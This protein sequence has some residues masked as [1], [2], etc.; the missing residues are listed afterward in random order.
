MVFERLFHPNLALT[1]ADK[2]AMLAHALVAWMYDASTGRLVTQF[3]AAAA[4]SYPLYYFTTSLSNDGT[5]VVFH[6]ERSGWVQ[7]Y[8]LDLF[9]RRR[10]RKPKPTSPAP[11]NA[12]VVGSGTGGGSS[13]FTFGV[14]PMRTC[15]TS[16]AS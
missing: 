14:R 13:S 11:S 1:L 8:R 2:R 5:Y 4:N 6:S 15:L 16:L 3:T 10:R 12:R 9:S 7:L